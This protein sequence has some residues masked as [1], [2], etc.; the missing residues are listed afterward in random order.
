[1]MPVH[2]LGGNLTTIPD[3]PP[4]CGG[5]G[6]CVWESITYFDQKADSWSQKSNEQKMVCELGNHFYRGGKTLE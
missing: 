1:M 2:H 6:V 3:F 5:K 4:M